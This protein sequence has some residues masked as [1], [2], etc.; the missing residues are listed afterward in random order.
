MQTNIKGETRSTC[1]LYMSH[2]LLKVEQSLK[3]Q[4]FTSFFKDYK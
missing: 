3:K 2:A 4:D 1:K